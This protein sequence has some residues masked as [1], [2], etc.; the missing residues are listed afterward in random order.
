FRT[1]FFVLCFTVCV[2]AEY[3][4]NLVGRVDPVQKITVTRENEEILHL[5]FFLI[6]SNN[7][8]NYVV[9]STELHDVKGGWF[10]MFGHKV[11]ASA[12]TANI[13]ELFLNKAKEEKVEITLGGHGEGAEFYF[14]SL[15]VKFITDTVRRKID[16]A[17]ASRKD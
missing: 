5:S 7:T 14:N 9:V 6:K 15:D 13:L 3:F 1:L 17:I 4:T 2:Q 8:N 12:K 11:R 10:G 16:F